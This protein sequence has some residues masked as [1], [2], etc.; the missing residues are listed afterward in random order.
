MTRAPRWPLPEVALER[1]TRETYRDWM[2][3][4][5]TIAETLM[6]DSAALSDWCLPGPADAGWLGWAADPTPPVV[7]I[8]S[9]LD[10]GWLVAA[11]NTPE[12]PRPGA[13]H[14]LTVAVKDIIDVAGLPVHNGTPGAAWR[15]PAQSAPAWARLASAGAQ[16]VGKA[17]THE[18]AW[19]VITPQIGHPLD[20]EWTTGGSSGGCAACVAARVCASA[21]GTDTGGSIRIPAALCG[22]VGFRPTTG[23]VDMRGITPLAPE[24]DVAGPFAQDTRTC[25]AM[26]EVLLHKPLGAKRPVSGLRVGVLREPGPLDSPT[27]RAY[28]RTVADLTRSG[29]RTI[30][31]DTKLP[32]HAGSISL[33]TML[34]SSAEQHAAAVQADPAGFGGEA[35]A[36]LTLGEELKQHAQLIADARKVL[37]AATASLFAEHDLDAFL[38]P[39]TPCVAPLRGVGTVEIANRAVP[40]SSALTRFTAWASVTGTPAISVPI[41]TSAA[42]VGAQIM[43]P[44]H[45]EAVCVA[46]ALR[47][48]QHTRVATDHEW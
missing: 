12:N 41:Q 14:G 17:A 4:A 10:E 16:C 45:G 37:T 31:V 24:M 43:A 39:T 34:L 19:G 15:E 47:I 9:A 30:A 7:S 29:V 38:T 20:R 42:P 40:V 48:E 18:M 44:P 32:R 36:L 13:L 33:L 26:L 8:D 23:S 28:E 22:V 11:A 1:A 21:L 46:L 3:R 2:R 5:I 35:R 25:A 6:A 27:G